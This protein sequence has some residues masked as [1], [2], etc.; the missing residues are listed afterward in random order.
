MILGGEVNT[1]LDLAE[2]LKIYEKYAKEVLAPT[3][4]ELDFLFEKWRDSQWNGSCNG[5]SPTRSPICHVSSRVKRPESVVDKINLDR[6]NVFPSKLCKKSL[7]T[8]NDTVAGRIIVYFLSDLPLL[9]EAIITDENIRVSTDNPPTAYL[10]QDLASRINIKDINIKTKESG[11][12]AIHYIVKFKDSKV[13]PEYRPW[14]EIQ[15]K[16]LTEHVWAEVE[17][18]LGYKPEAG[19]SDIIK[20]QFK[21]IGKHLCAIDEHFDLLFDDMKR[22]QQGAKY[23]PEDIL[24]PEN[25]ASVLSNVGLCCAQ[26]EVGRMLKIFE[27]WGIKYVNEIVDLATTERLSLIRNIYLSEL[28]Y[29]PDSSEIIANLVVLKGISDSTQMISSIKTQIEFHKA[30]KTLKGEN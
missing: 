12:N 25:L 15:L 8:L 18:L 2:F 11:Y 23:A 26:N 4:N 13:E 20:K 27:S 5:G 10:T 16:T 3:K 30:W 7:R 6:L 24:N 21:I 14:F 17:H 9:H 29:S 28:D 1:T 19:P 22:A